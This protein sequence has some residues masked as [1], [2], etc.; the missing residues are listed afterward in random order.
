MKTASVRQVQHNLADV[1]R[2]VEEGEEFQ[3]LRRNRPVAKLIPIQDVYMEKT[4]DWAEHRSEVITIFKG[5]TITG[6]PMEKIVSEAR[7][8]Y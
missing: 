3:I 7:G 8:D 5:R 1:L 2:Q 6:K 4:V